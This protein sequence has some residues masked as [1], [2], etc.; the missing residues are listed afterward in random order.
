M[1]A[2]VSKALIITEGE[3]LEKAFFSRM[4]DV[5]SMKID[6]YT[7]KTNV[8][9][10]YDD[11]IKE[12]KDGLPSDLIEV[13][14]HRKMNTSEEIK[15]LSNDFVYVYLIFD[16]DYHASD[17]KHNIVDVIEYLTK[18]FDNETEDGKLYV[19]YPMMDSIY[20]QTVIGEDVYL[21][22]CIQISDSSNYKSI[23]HKR[24]NNKHISDYTVND[25]NTIAKQNAIKASL[26]YHID[27]LNYASFEKV[28]NQNKTLELVL[29]DYVSNG[30]IPIFNTS[31]M[32]L[33]DYFGERK[34]VE[35]FL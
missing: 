19:N 26:I 8:I 28:T 25:F 7:F 10:L 32:L 30:I 13:L 23:V 34:F 17:N 27:L 22:K 5:F 9:S 24:G 6:I 3:K 16:F 21:E 29:A 14:R 33:I 15:I 11:L 35:L 31:S 2:S 20:D 12:E 18:R 1:E 4:K